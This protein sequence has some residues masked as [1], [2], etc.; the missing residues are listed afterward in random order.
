MILNLPWHR[1]YCHGMALVRDHL[2]WIDGQADAMADLLAEWVG[3]SSGTEHLPGLERMLETLTDHF[4]PLADELRHLELPPRPVVDDA[5][6][7]V[8][9]PLG[10][11]LWLRRRAEAA[12]RVLLNIHMDTVFGP[13]DPFNSAQRPAPDRM[14]GPGAA[15][16]K[17][18]LV[19]M[20]TA[21]QAL[22]QSEVA[23]HLGY[24]VLI[25][26]DEELGSP[27]SLPLLAD[28][29]RRCDLGLVF[30][31]ALEDGA[32][33]SQRKGSG[34]FVLV[35][36]G[37]SAHAGRNPDDG[38]NAV[39][40]LARAIAALDALNGELPGLT[41][42]VGRVVGG[43]AVNMVPGLALCRFNVRYADPAHERRLRQRLAEIVQQVEQRDGVEVELHGEFAAPPKLLDGPTALLMDHV[44]AVGRELDV[45][46]TWRS[47]GGVSDGNRLA[48]AGLANLDTMGPRGGE[49]H[50][51][52]EF[53]LLD[54][55]PERAK[56]TA[57]LLV[58]L[59]AGSLAWPGESA[60]DATRGA[61]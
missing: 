4:D 19:V 46:I 7:V 38:R 56:L 12:H 24:E 34:G 52:R 60:A 42:N 31:P 51:D 55:L 20:L 13:D 33:V 39:T 16:G 47:T 49:L 25:N 26:P 61:G 3:I 41:V 32:M 6:R 22:E 5:G 17:G 28:C 2:D 45:P 14:L 57:G 43:S 8:H 9:Q 35:V 30:E 1:R 36:R 37:R 40:A 53:V 18:G 59:A 48:A 54:S 50:S 44:A 21:L 29:A 15:D 23:H 27:G 11:A 10:K 58:N